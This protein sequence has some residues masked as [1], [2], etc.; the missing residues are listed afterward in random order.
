MEATAPDTELAAPCGVTLAVCPTCTEPIDASGTLTVTS[1]APAPTMTMDLLSLEALPARLTEP[2][3]PAMEDFRVAQ[4]RSAWALFRSASALVTAAWS[5]T[6]LAAPDWFEAPAAPPEDWLVADWEVADWDV[7]DWLV[8][9]DR[10][11]VAD[12]FTVGAVDW[13]GFADAGGAFDK[14]VADLA[15]RAADT[16]P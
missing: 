10:L 14:S 9:P 15:M 11:V 2:T 12:A 6:T 7:T 13:R 8:D 4:A 16:A 3:V 1:T 5:E